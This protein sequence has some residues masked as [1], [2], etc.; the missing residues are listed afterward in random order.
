M[1]ITV[2]DIVTP[3]CVCLCVIV[4][5]IVVTVFLGMAII[6]NFAMALRNY[7][8]RFSSKKAKSPSKK[9]ET[10]EEATATVPDEKK[11]G[12]RW[13]PKLKSGSE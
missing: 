13:L 9:N 5:A 6:G 4:V 10:E 2:K 3:A 8:I 12:E 7:M 11:E 1:T